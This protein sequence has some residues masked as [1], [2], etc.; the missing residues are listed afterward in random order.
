MLCVL[1]ACVLGYCCQSRGS[2][3]TVSVYRS[4]SES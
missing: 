1:T 4:G 3:N 2:F